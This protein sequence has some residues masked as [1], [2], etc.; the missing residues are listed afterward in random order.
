MHWVSVD[1]ATPTAD[2]SPSAVPGP[3]QAFGQVHRALRENEK[4]ISSFNGDLREHGQQMHDVTALLC[5]RRPNFEATLWPPEA[6][7]AT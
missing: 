1:T 4:R 7:P 5:R 6:P 3:L 2:P